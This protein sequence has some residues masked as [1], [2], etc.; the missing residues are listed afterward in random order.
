MVPIPQLHLPGAV[1]R[2]SVLRGHTTRNVPP[3]T[4]DSAMNIGVQPMRPLVRTKGV[5]PSHRGTR[6]VFS[7]GA[8]SVWGG[9][10]PPGGSTQG[11]RT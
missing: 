1:H 8:H 10:M 6:S 2:P 7:N 9:R 11:A 4:L 5:M 3:R